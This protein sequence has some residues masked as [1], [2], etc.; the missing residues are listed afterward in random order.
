MFGVFCG[1]IMHAYIM[2]EYVFRTVVSEKQAHEYL[3]PILAVELM[4]LLYLT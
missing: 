4:A 1:T 2:R 3:K